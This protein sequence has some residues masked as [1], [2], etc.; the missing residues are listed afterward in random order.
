MYRQWKQVQVAWNECRN[1]IWTGR[2][3]IRKVKAQME[4]NLARDLKNNKKGFYRHIGYK[5]QAEESVPLC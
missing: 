1:V 2:D 3:G 5:R 4:L